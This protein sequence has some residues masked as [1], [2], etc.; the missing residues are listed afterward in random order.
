LHTARL[1]DFYKP[2]P[3]TPEEMEAMKKRNEAKAAEK[4]RKAK[5]ASEAKKGG[6]KP[7]LGA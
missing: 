3:K 5:S 4:K 7:K 1:G 2:I 6:K